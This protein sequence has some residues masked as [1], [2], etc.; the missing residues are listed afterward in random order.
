MAP[1]K[2]F[3]CNEIWGGNTHAAEDVELGKLR[4][5][6][7]SIPHDSEKG[8]DIHYLCQCEPETLAKIVIADVA[9]HGEVV[10]AIAE[11][12]RRLLHA[13]LNEVDNSRLLTSVN[14]VLRQTLPDGRFV[15][16]VA[17]TYNGETGDFIY[18]Y[19]GHPT[20]FRFS[21]TGGRWQFLQPVDAPNSGVPLGI[22]GGT[23]YVQANARLQEGDMLLF[24]TDGVLDIRRKPHERLNIN[25]LLEV[26]Q[27][28]TDINSG[29]RHVVTSLVRHL[30]EVCEGEFMD[31][32]TL[33][34]L[35]VC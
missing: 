2:K 18:A 7:L 32:V 6:L 35:Q 10:S 27:K 29:P 16:M 5:Y 15:T 28:V 1:G 33:L 9:G 25:G 8:G 23:E 24:Y 4:G 20:I 31:D 30:R 26:C 13:D 21:V 11:Q 22:L 3:V 34:A 14:E 12:M 17:A 19:A